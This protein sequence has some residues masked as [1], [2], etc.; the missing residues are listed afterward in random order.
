MLGKRHSILSKARNAFALHDMTKNF[1]VPSRQ[2]Q[3]DFPLRE[4][5]K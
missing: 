5:A 3:L 4:N 1:G 2:Q